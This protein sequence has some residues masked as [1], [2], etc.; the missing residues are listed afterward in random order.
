MRQI[1]VAATLILG[2][3]GTVYAIITLIRDRG[4]LIETATGVLDYGDAMFGSVTA[5]A[6]VI[7][8]ISFGLLFVSW[9]LY[10]SLKR[11]AKPEQSVPVKYRELPPKQNNFGATFKALCK[12]KPALV[13][14]ILVLLLFA[15]AYIG[16]M[17]F[18]MQDAL[19][20]SVKRLDPPSVEHW[21]GTD[22]LGRDYFARI[23]NGASVSLTMGFLPVGVSML[24]G[25]LLGALAAYIGGWVDNLIMRICDI[26]A[27]I[28][29]ILLSITLV[30]VLGT[31]LTNMLVAI[32]ITS[33][34]GRIR[35][36]R[37]V[38]LQVVG[39]DYIEAARCCGTKTLG[40]I[41][42]HIVPNAFGPLLLNATSSIAGMIMLGAGLSFLG[43]G[44]EPPY[45]E[46]GSM[47]MDG[48]AHIL[49][50]PHMI[51]FPGIFLILSMLGFNLLGDGLR[52]VLDPKLK[53]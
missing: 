34:P 5:N 29:G 49:T 53:R 50:S 20:I 33:I 37:S 43:L 45:P 47:L 2:I 38:V 46:W 26:F 42:K 51:Y 7:I 21:F 17:F 40:L 9:R 52:D 23:V 11:L 36:V 24:V 6:I 30:A 25:M 8:L 18:P 28:P 27:C 3:L 12:N 41:F 31:G 13:G 22:N 32:T 4:G 48:R 44:L 14:L 10:L 19:R 39:Q 35:F 15:F 16:P 1:G